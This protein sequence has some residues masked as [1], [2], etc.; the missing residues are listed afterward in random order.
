MANSSCA[1]ISA[2][3]PG[4]LFE[5]VARSPNKSFRLKANFL[6]ARCLE[7]DRRWN[8][9]QEIWLGLLPDAD[10]VPGGKAQ[11]LYAIG[12]C[13]SNFE[14]PEIDA[15]L[16]RWYQVLRHGRNGSPGRGPMRIGEA[17]ISTRIDDVLDIWKSRAGQRL[18]KPADYRNP[19]LSLD[20]VRQNFD[21]AYGSFRDYQKFQES[22]KLAELYQRIALPGKAELYLAKAYEALA[23]EQKT[24]AQATPFYENAARAYEQLAQ[25][26]PPEEQ[27]DNLWRSAGCHQQARQFTQAIRVLEKFVK[28]EKNDAR[29][30]QGWLALA[31]A[32]LDLHHA[33]PA[34]QAFMRCVDLVGTPQADQARLRLARMEGSKNID[35]ALEWIKPISPRTLDRTAYEGALYLHG[36]L[37]LQAEKYELAHLKLKEAIDQF[38]HHAGVFEARHELAQCYR[39]LA[40]LAE[41][42]ANRTSTPDVREHYARERLKWLQ[43]TAKTY[44]SLADDLLENCPASHSFPNELL[45]ILRLASFGVADALRD[46]GD[47]LGSGCAATRS[48]RRMFIAIPMRA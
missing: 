26:C 17:C 33:E 13:L 36:F 15:A 34:R 32:H 21:R 20:Q 12:V 40:D 24:P 1:P 27:T 10:E 39:K 8:Q 11:V 16:E 47:N 14:P 31:E 22:A 23:R 38:P 28:T 6:Q 3:G 41:D 37:F 7:A 43:A 5:S 18:Y 9:A 4:A 19:Y 44:Q 45:N 42:K 35:R 25:S 46:S 29:I 30:A 48:C 2:T